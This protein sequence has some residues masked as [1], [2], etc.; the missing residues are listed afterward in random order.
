MMERRSDRIRRGMELTRRY[1]SVA[2]V[3]GK[4]YG[5]WRDERGEHGHAWD[6]VWV[7]RGLRVTFPWLWPGPNGTSVK[8]IHVLHRLEKYV[9]TGEAEGAD[10]VPEVWLG[11]AMDGAT[12]MIPKDR[13][14][15]VLAQ[16]A[17]TGG[18]GDE[19]G[20]R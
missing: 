8:R 3:G 13:L 9:P 5:S 15:D 1:F 14:E 17:G 16:A 20:V 7:R 10:G 12:M 19:E 4:R 2:V 18:D 11:F 6:R